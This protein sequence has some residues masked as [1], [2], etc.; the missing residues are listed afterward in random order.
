MHSQY[1]VRGGAEGGERLRILSR[2]MHASSM[3]LLERLALRDGLACLD[4]GCG[5]GDVTFELARRVA[6]HGQAVGV[7]I[8]AEKL[9]IAR[10]EARE[11]GVTNVVFQQSNIGETPG[12]AGFDIVY[13]RFL[14]THLSSPDLALR[15]LC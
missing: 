9:A 3:T 11:Q 6:P 14:L 1:V 15:T 2:V 8:D 10:Q 12:A 13:S 7:D 4:A 5:G